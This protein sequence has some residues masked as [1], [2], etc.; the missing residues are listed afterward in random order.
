MTEPIEGMPRLWPAGD[1]KPAAQP[2]WLARNRMPR[3]SVSLLIGDEGIGKSLW[4]VLVV[5]AITTG[6]P[7]PEMGI[8]AR[9]PASAILVLTEDTWSEDVLPRLF[10]AGAN[11]ANIQV[12]CTEQ[13]GSGAPVF[14]RDIF[15]IGEATPA[16]ALIVVDCWLDTVA[17]SLSVRDPQQARQALHPWREVATAT[18]AAVLLLG[19]TNR[20]SSGNARDKYG[21]TAALRQKARM[22]LFAQHDDD[23][24]LVVGPEKANGTA[25]VAASR[26]TVSPVQYFEPSEEHDGLCRCC[27]TSATRLSQL[28]STSPTAMR[29]STVK[30]NRTATKP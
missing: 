22:T 28:A 24:N 21:A 26:F 6:K 14:P 5:A 10:V 20:I 17:A 4:W 25:P 30:I 18:D 8:P 12:I 2:R 9:E 15:L 16:P 1:L 7:V 29:Q 19:H 23:G 3:R 27:G 11:I 13:D